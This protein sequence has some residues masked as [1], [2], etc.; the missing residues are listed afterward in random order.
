M[1][2]YLESNTQLY[3]SFA[4]HQ[5]DQFI[6]NAKA[7]HDVAMMGIFRYLQGTKNK[8]LVFNM[9]KNMVVYLYAGKD[10]AGP[11]VHEN[12]QYPNC[13]S[14]KTRFVVIFANYPILWVSEIYT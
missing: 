6:N 11:C 12:P 14:S 13:D 10:F 4:V 5:C 9:S 3:I 8:G 2:L 1:I 7:S